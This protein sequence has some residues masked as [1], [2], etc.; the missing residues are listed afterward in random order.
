MWA[1]LKEMRLRKAIRE[2]KLKRELMS[3]PIREETPK[4]SGSNEVLGH[5]RK[6]TSAGDPFGG[7]EACSVGTEEVARTG[8]RG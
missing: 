4:P 2:E 7:G 5:L 1:L 3:K 6:E 8:T